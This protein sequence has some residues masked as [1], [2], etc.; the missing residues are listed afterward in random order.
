MH[1]DEIDVGAGLVVELLRR[2]FPQLADLSLTRVASQGTVNAIYRLG[3][4]H[5][6]RLPLTP[7]WHDIDAEA[8]WLAALGPRLPVRIP[9]VVAIGEADDIYPWKWGVMRWLDGSPWSLDAVADPVESA[10]QL[11]EMIL[12]LR[13]LDPRSLRCGKPPRRPSLSAL[14]E[15]VRA[16]IEANR[17]LVD[18][19]AFLAAWDD[20]LQAPEFDGKPPL[21]HGDLLAGNVLVHDGR[22]HAV[23]DWAGIGR[24]DPARELMAAWMLFAGESRA[25][26]RQAL[27]AD[28]DTWRRAKGWVLT[29]IFG[30]AYYEKSNPA[31]SLDARRAIAEVLADQ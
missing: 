4:D 3:D 1:H 5:V 12:V 11:A 13:G 14:D 26:F 31:F 24:A 27:S 15:G 7:N 23:I 22:L 8:C 6:L 10:L 28:D 30:V 16:A 9:E 17:H 29:R 18:G 19:D 20:A 21:C 25:A 2:Q